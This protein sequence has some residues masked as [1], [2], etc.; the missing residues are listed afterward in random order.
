MSGGE[1]VLL[2]D[3]GAATIELTSAGQRSRPTEFV[4]PRVFAVNDFRESWPPF[5]LGP[6]W[7]IYKSKM[8]S[9]SDGIIII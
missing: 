7:L 4:F 2:G 1:H 3:E 9:Q 6:T 8:K 5:R